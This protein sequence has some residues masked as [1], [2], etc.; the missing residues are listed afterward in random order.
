MIP[1]KLLYPDFVPD[2]LLTSEDLNSLF[3]YLDEQGRLTRTNL[4]G[5]GIVCGLEI[6]INPQYFAFADPDSRETAWPRV[7][8]L[9]FS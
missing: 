9:S 2:Q 4:I 8:A 7:N 5:V 3:G 1:S 6:V